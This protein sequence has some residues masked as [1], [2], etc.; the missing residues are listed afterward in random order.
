MF[1]VCVLFFSEPD[2]SDGVKPK[3]AFEISAV[4]MEYSIF[5]FTLFFCQLLTNSNDLHPIEYC[6]VATDLNQSFQLIV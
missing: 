6:A 4:G 1:W 2:I 5:S 3:V